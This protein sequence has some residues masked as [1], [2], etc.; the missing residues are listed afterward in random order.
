MKSNE[1]RN[2]DL[3][4]KLEEKGIP[5]RES[6]KGRKALENLASKSKAHKGP[7][8]N[9]YLVQVYSNKAGEWFTQDDLAKAPNFKVSNR[10]KVEF[11]CGRDQLEAMLFS[12]NLKPSHRKDLQGFREK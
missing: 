2:K 11:V 4:R 8:T 7:P 3:L 1:S 9:S 10:W 6:K 5:Y 12:H